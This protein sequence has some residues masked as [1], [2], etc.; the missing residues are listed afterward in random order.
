MPS[1]RRIATVILGALA[2]GAFAAWA[3]GPGTDGVQTMSQLRAD[4]GNLSTPWL[5]VACLAGA[6]CARPRAG[7]LLGLMATV[8]AL[9]SFYIV[10][11]LFVDLGGSGFL[12]NLRLELSANRAYFQGGL[13]TGPIFGAL[14]A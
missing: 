12:D 13:V 8:V 11:T 14:G 6:Q 10:T 4:L 9:T 2:F 3:K 7:A 1:G 5:L